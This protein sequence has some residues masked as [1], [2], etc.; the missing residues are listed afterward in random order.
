M[1]TQALDFRQA[2]ILVAGDVMIDQYWLGDASRI[3]PEAPVPVVKIQGNDFR[4]GGA[5]NAALN[6]SSL[7]SQVTLAG[8]IGNDDD[9]RMYQKLLSE[10]NIQSLHAS[11]QESSTIKKLRIISRSQ[12]VLRADFEA[13][14]SPSA[15]SQVTENILSAI[16]K[17]DI[18]L[19]SDYA[20]GCLIDCPSIIQQANSL[21]IPVV[22]D[23]KGSDYTKYT[24]AH[25]IT[26]NLQEFELVVGHCENEQDLFHKA[27]ALIEKISLHALLLT[28]SEK[29]MTLFLKDGSHHH[30]NAQ[31][32]EVF[33][34]T[35][36]G[37]T[38]IATLASAMATKQSISDAVNLANTAASVVVGKMGTVAI[39]PLDL[40]VALE[41][42][43]FSPSGILSLNALKNAVEFEKTLGKKIVF[44]NGCFD[45]LHAGHVQY[46]QEAAA[47][48]DRLIV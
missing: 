15:Q 20:K 40:K 2:N 37:D 21:G 47:L 28:R 11:C 26:P 9:G 45:I 14:F 16:A 36:A 34:V 8:I 31:A 42:Q 43:S 46:L 6:C 1:T 4:L 12:Q 33:D 7:G 5:A 13:P 18:V 3:S 23:P 19:L 38:V 22:I 25:L 35:G 24:G 27:H 17:Q 48:G 10:H 44:T 41:Q 29:G 30:F 39:T 32:K